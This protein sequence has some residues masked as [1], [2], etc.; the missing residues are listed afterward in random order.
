[1]CLHILFRLISI[2]FSEYCHMIECMTVDRFWINDSIYLT[3]WYSVWLQFTVHY[4]T[5]THTP[6]VYAVMSSLP[7]LGSGFQRQ[8][9]PFL[10][11][12]NCLPPQLP[13]CNSS[14]LQRLN[15]SSSLADSNCQLV[16]L[17]TSQHGLHRKRLFHLFLLYSHVAV[18]ARLFDS[19][20]FDGHCLAAG[21]HATISMREFLCCF[22]CIDRVNL[23]GTPWG[24]EHTQNV[25]LD[26][27]QILWIL[28]TDHHEFF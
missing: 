8:M 24:Y 28:V 23:I 13:A 4:Y 26:G 14:S 22:I 1:M 5:H 21:L 16:L 2:R 12:P 3:L 10:W 18:K 7:L 25:P 27:M 15:L 19:C 17:I 9:F 6:L 11:V 20:L